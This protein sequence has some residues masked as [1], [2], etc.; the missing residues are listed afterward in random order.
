MKITHSPPGPWKWTVPLEAKHPWGTWLVW[1]A[2]RRQ[3][4]QR[5]DSSLWRCSRKWDKWQVWLV[6]LSSEMGAPPCRSPG[7]LAQKYTEASASLYAPVPTFLCCQMFGLWAE[8]VPA[9][10]LRC[11]GSHRLTFMCQWKF[12][13][14]CLLE[15]RVCGPPPAPFYQR[16]PRENGSFCLSVL[17]PGIFLLGWFPNSLIQMNSVLSSPMSSS[18]AMSW[19]GI[20]SYLGGCF[21]E[22]EAVCHPSL[23]V[24]NVVDDRRQLSTTGLY[25]TAERRVSPLLSVK[26]TGNFFQTPLGEN[27]LSWKGYFYHLQIVCT[28]KIKNIIF[29]PLNHA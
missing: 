7:T 27:L 4:S 2:G 6:N 15:M 10:C 3:L 21:E 9:G 29:L 19:D 24:P 16:L 26:W 12:G 13:N 1:K 8:L 22:W 23:D 11:P 20:S 25:S 17:L 14:A 28:N 5:H 18:H